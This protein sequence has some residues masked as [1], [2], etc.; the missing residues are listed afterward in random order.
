[1]DVMIHEKVRLRWW[2]LAMRL[3]SHRLVDAALEFMC[4]SHLYLPFGRK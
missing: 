3:P 4:L 1:M 2:S